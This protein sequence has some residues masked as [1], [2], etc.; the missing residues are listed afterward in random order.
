MQ[1]FRF[2]EVVIYPIRIAAVVQYAID[3]RFSVLDV[4]I[5]GKWKPAG[6]CAMESEALVVD[7]C[8]KGK[9]F[10][11]SIECVAKIV[12]HAWLL[13]FVEPIAVANVVVGGI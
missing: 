11:L 10:D 9:R 7:A 6:E 4:I 13:I 2:L 3:A 5:D 1:A 8:V 12:A